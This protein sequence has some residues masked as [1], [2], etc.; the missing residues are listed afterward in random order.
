MPNDVELNWLYTPPS[1][2]PNSPVETRVQ[3]L[4]FEKLRWEDFEKLCYRL[5]RLEAAVDFCLPY[6]VPGQAQYGI[7]IFAKISGAEKYRVYQCK[8]QR[9]FGPAKIAEAIET[10][11]KGKWLAKSET[12]VLCNRESLRSTDRVEEFA[13]QDKILRDHKISLLFWDAE[14]LSSKLKS[15]PEIIDDFFG[16]GWVKAFCGQEAADKLGERLDAV[17]IKE[18]RTQLQSLYERIFNL[19]DRGIPLSDVPFAERYIVPDV[20]DHQVIMSSNESIPKQEDSTNSSSFQTQ[21]PS[22]E[23]PSKRS[24]RF[25]TKRLP[26]QIWI[27][28][29]KRNLIFGEPGSG[30]SAFLRFL[31]LDL[32]KD[33]PSFIEVAEKWGTHVPIWI[34]F[35][36]WTKVPSNNQGGDSS[37]KGIFTNWLKSWDA[38]SLIPLIEKALKDKRLLLLIDGLDEYSNSDAAQIVLNRLESFFSQNEVPIIVTSRPQGFE[39]IGMKVEGW[40][41]TQ[42]APMN[43]EQQERLTEIW[44]EA[45]SKRIN[46]ALDNATRSKDVRRQVDTFFAELSR[47]NELRELARNPLLL[48]LLISFQISRIRLPIGRFK[49]YAALTDHL[50][51]AHPEARRIAADNA[52]SPQELSEE[53][54]KKALAHLATVMHSNYPEGSMHENKALQVIEDFLLNDQYGFGLNQRAAS[55]TGKNILAT[56]E[57]NL[58]IIVKRSIDEIGFYHRTMQEYLVSFNIS[59]LS[60]KEQS[61]IIKKCYA[62]PLWREVILG[63]FQIIGRPDDVRQL[64]DV[65]KKSNSDSL[66]GKMAL[67]LLSEIA[68]GDFNCPPNLAKDLAMQTFN[69][70]ELSTWLPYREKLL[71]HALDGLRSTTLGELVK[72]KISDWFPD[73]AGWSSQYI[74]RSMSGWTINENLIEVLFKGLNDEEYNVKIAVAKTLAKVANHDDNIGERLVRLINYT[75]DA[76]IV[77]ASLETLMIGWPDHPKL[78]DFIER[79]V[80]S[81]LPVMELAGIKGKVKKGIQNDND[82]EILLKLADRNSISYSLRSEVSPIIMEGWPKSEKV[83]HIC[84]ESLVERGGGREKNSHSLEREDS[85]AILLNGYP[86]DEEVVDYCVNELKME[87]YPFSSLYHDAFSALAQNFKGHPKLIQALDEWI[88]KTEFQDVEASFAAQVGK[89]GI[90]KQRLIEN[91]NDSI[92]HWAVLGLVQGWTMQDAEVSKVLLEIAESPANRASKI[93]YLIPQIVVDHKKCRQILLAILKD[94]HCSRYDFVIE[95]LIELGNT[96]QDFEVVDIVL[97]ILKEKTDRHFEIDGMKSSLI[98]NYNFDPRVRQ[99]A[100]ETLEERDGEYAAVAFAFGNDPE[101]RAKILKMVNPLPVSMR[102][103]IAK[104]LSEAEIDETYAM[105]ILKLYDHERDKEVKVQSSIGYYTRLKSSGL[106]TTAVLQRLTKDITCVGPDYHERRMAAFCGLAILDRLDLMRDKKEMYGSQERGAAIESIFGMDLNVPHIQFILRNWEKLKDAFKDEFWNRLFRYASDSSYIWNILAQ[107]ADEYPAP[108]SEILDYLK[109]TKNKIAESESLYFLS[110]VMPGSELLFEYCFNTLTFGIK[111]VG[112][113]DYPTNKN[114]NH[115][116]QLAAAEIMGDNF[117]GESSALQKI[118]TN[119]KSIMTDE[120]IL[121]LSEGWPHSQELDSL[122][123]EL[124]TSRRRCWTTTVIRYYSF[125]A[126]VPSMYKE[127]IRLI[128]QYSSFPRYRAYEE[129]VRPLVRRIAEDDSFNTVLVKHLGIAKKSADKVSISKLIYKSRG[130]T[131]ELKRWAEQ[132]LEIQLSGNCIEAGFDI[133]S[134]EFKSIPHVLYEIL[135]IS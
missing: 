101:I 41:Q 118:Y 132:E 79:S 51:S 9:D 21:E 17:A 112:D 43:Q 124:A 49:V 23:T 135:Q 105:S 42:I 103:A 134:G 2:V 52:V 116:D 133:T 59:R 60:L 126:K 65:I 123:R 91:L 68:F 8:N 70:I 16:R 110:K 29:N 7:D 125:K 47:S 130:L 108:R 87:K 69:D 104:Y 122:L 26:I 78:N 121:V 114:I 90:F 119:M 27:V 12:F 98:K 88:Q 99:L 36:L 1:Q 97:K 19:H 95:G 94:R 62:N 81:P 127:L 93:A 73:R 113:T 33:T 74:F 34:P 46:P 84:L 66:E 37:V 72:Q 18:L 109:T 48:C 22:H 28:R 115:R 128:R 57:D 20:E 15:Y 89:T 67:D 32:L 3:L 24:K 58:G 61:E 111:L 92:P 30:K 5:A 11:V 107:F 44:F 100:L 131:P 6:G 83:K 45:S 63:L 75:D 39:K 129:V 50:I 4:P 80:N 31:A 106:D 38:E 64:I 120:L 76:Y 54:I 14:E 53:E 96:D 13:K 77:A 25:Y 102:Q 82:L 117:G 56:A 55:K 40:Q 85:L 10:F 35:A 86:M 71:K